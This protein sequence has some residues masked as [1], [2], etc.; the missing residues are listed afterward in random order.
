MTTPQDKEFYKYCYNERQSYRSSLDKKPK[1]L[2]VFS[3]LLKHLS[4][5]YPVSIPNI[6]QSVYDKHMD[7][8]YL[9]EI[10]IAQKNKLSLDQA[11][12]IATLKRHTRHNYNNLNGVLLQKETY[13]LPVDY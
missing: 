6:I 3:N 7:I 12:Q 13:W 8:M 1:W 10:F 9:Y 11:V 5:K 4:H 2:R